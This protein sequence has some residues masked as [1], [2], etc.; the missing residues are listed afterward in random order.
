MLSVFHENP[1]EIIMLIRTWSSLIASFFEM[2]VDINF[3]L[4]SAS[5]NWIIF[6]IYFLILFIFN[7]LSKLLL[8]PVHLLII[9]LSHP[10]LI[11][12]S[13]SLSLILLVSKLAVLV[14]VVVAVRIIKLLPISS[15]ISESVF[16]S[17]LSLSFGY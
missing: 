3:P 11:S 1:I 15:H 5:L 14:A 8:W 7:I 12:V 17:F 2:T 9:L 10:P 13:M 4:I 16:L 6:F